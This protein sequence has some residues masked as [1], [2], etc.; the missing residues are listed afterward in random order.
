MLSV[1]FGHIKN[2]KDCYK[3]YEVIVPGFQKMN[4]LAKFKRLERKGERNHMVKDNGEFCVV[5][6][7]TKKTVFCGVTAETI[8][9]AFGLC[10][11]TR[12]KLP[13]YKSDSVVIK[14]R[15]KCTRISDDYIPGF[16]SGRKQICKDTPVS[17]IDKGKAHALRDAGWSLAMIADEFSTNERII[18]K[19]LELV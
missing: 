6:L 13:K 10:K 11:A 2:Q 9:N 7:K 14:R 15:Y 1:Y 17:R 19:A 16:N 3:T 18:S 4:V 5:D 8:K 12:Y